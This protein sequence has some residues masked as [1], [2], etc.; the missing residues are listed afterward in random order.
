MTQDKDKKKRKRRKRLTAEKKFEIFLET[1][2]EDTVNAEVL[3]REG[4]YASDLQRIRKQV[5]EGA[6]EGLKAAR[7][8]GPSEEERRIAKLEEELHKR[9]EVISQLSM[10]RMV[11]SKKVNGE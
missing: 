10:E 9:D 5:K 11:L 6:I 3:R 1:A 2:R 8:R 4:L 7:K